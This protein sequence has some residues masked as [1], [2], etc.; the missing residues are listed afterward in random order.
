MALKHLDPK[1]TVDALAGV[2]D[3]SDLGHFTDEERFRPAAWR[4]WWNTSNEISTL[5]DKRL[6]RP[7]EADERCW[8]P[9][10]DPDASVTLEELSDAELVSKLEEARDNLMDVQYRYALLLGLVLGS[11]I[12]SRVNDGKEPGP[13]TVTLIGAVLD[14]LEAMDTADA[15][16][17]LR[18]EEHRRQFRETGTT[19]FLDK[20]RGQ[21]AERDGDDEE[22]PAGA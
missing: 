6:P 11:E 8:R 21:L 2:V 19:P 7:P 1:L 22:R 20:L 5:L 15:M 16:Q 10:V 18:F 3:A 12:R 17:E 9:F 4:R 13:H 14:V